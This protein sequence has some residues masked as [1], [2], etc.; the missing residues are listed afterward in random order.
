M[1]NE[2]KEIA[3]RYKGEDYKDCKAQLVKDGFQPMGF[4]EWRSPVTGSAYRFVLAEGGAGYV[5]RV[6]QI[7]D[8]GLQLI[9][10]EFCDHSE[11]LSRYNAEHARPSG[12]TLDGA[13]QRFKDSQLTTSLSKVLRLIES[14]KE[15]G[16]ADAALLVEQIDV[17]R[18][19]KLVIKNYLFCNGVICFYS[20]VRRSTH[21]LVE[22]LEHNGKKLYLYRA[23]IYTEDLLESLASKVKLI[24]ILGEDAVRRISE[25]A[26]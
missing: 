15:A 25:S 24:R 20:P 19:G 1:N 18:K 4:N 26:V 2:P 5:V 3:L 12:V 10:T 9:N 23:R 13:L 6:E 14:E 7:T 16:S 8:E 22:T 21:E 17:E 11:A